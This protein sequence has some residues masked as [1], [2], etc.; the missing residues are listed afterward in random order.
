MMEMGAR[1]RGSRYG[2]RERRWVWGLS[3]CNTEGEKWTDSNFIL[4]AELAVLE[5]ECSMQKREKV[6]GTISRR[7]A[8]NLDW[9]QA[10]K[11]S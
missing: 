10:G 4:E 8:P 7:G 1:L 2:S 3:H 9:R 5:D 6:S 11:A